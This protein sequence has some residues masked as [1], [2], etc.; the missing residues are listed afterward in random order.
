MPLE[1]RNSAGCVTNALQHFVDG[2]RTG[3][4]FETD[5]RDTLRTMRLV[6]ACYESAATGRAVEI[7]G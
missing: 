2:V 3:A 1:P 7:I 5:G 6:Y 4:P